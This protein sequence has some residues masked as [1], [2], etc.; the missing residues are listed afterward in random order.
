MP[1][2]CVV[3][4]GTVGY[5]TASYINQHGFQVCGYD[6]NERKVEGFEVF[7]DWGKVPPEIEIFVVTVSTSLGGGILDASPIFDVGRKIADKNR[8]CLVSIESTIPVGTC[9]RVVD[10]FGLDYLVHVPHRYWVGDPER[11]GVRQMRVMGAIDEE[12]LKRGLDFY[13]QLDIPIHVARTIEIVEMCK[14]V[15]NAHRYVEIAF[16]ESVAIICRQMGLPF[17]KVQEASNT[18]WNTNILEAREGIR[19]ECLTMCIDYLHRQGR[20]GTPLLEGAIQA[21]KNY[22]EFINQ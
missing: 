22:R 1:K 8:H 10:E 19:G 7:T 20:K 13:G 21:D 5:P 4:I 16:A 15:E 3:G 6:V 12:S 18:K 17:D 9:R 11:Y 2:V 14:L